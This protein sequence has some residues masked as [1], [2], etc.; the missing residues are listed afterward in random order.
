MTAALR[1]WGRRLLC[2]NTGC[3]VR[4]FAH[5]AAEIVKTTFRN[6][7][8]HR[9]AE[10]AAALAFYG[11]LA[12]AGL[13]LVVLFCATHF[14]AT[15][16]AAHAAT[17]TGQVAGAHNGGE[18]AA[19]LRE[20]ASSSDAWIALVAGVLLFAGA[21]VATAL[22]LQQLLNVVW[23][24]AASRSGAAHDARRHTPQLAAMCAL[25][26]VLLVLLFCGAAV[27]GLTM[28]THRLGL[29]QGIGYQAGVVVITIVVLTI[30]FLCMFAYVSPVKARWRDVW[31]AAAL[32]AVLYERGQF[33]LSVY[34][35]QMDVRSPY[36]DAGALA[37]VLLWLYY[38]AQVVVIGA[39]LTKTLK[40]RSECARPAK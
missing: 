33:A 11:A 10:M 19:V 31:I 6:W 30:V 25:A 13:A 38:S 12:L 29:V 24:T 9:S 14:A 17:L 7:K 40:E 5:T 28:H 39:D 37:A 20:S 27:H 1:A 26:F 15:S 23:G 32:S 16:V 22:Q 3:I 4:R 35:G 2:G 34:V 18:V 8:Q 36:A 21:I